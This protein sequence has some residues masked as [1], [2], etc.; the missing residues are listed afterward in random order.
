MELPYEE[1]LSTLGIL[2]Y[3]NHSTSMGIGSIDVNYWTKLSVK[4]Y[5]YIYIYILYIY[6]YIF[7]YIYILYIYIYIHK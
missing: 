3:T 6:I 1:D 7:I 4:T 2:T 5:I